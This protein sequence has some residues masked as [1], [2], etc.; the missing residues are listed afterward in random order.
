MGLS[1]SEFIRRRLAQEASAGAGSVTA[2]DLASFADTFSDLADPE[3][4][5]HA[6]E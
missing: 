2:A 6:W 5:R 4:M 3:I 1:R